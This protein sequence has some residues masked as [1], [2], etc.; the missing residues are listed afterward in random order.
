MKTLLTWE[1]IQIRWGVF[2]KGAESMEAAVG[3]MW[4]QYTVIMVHF[5]FMGWYT[6][7]FTDSN[8]EHN[9]VASWWYQQNLA[10]Y[11]C[12]SWEWS[13]GPQFLLDYMLTDFLHKKDKTS[14]F[15]VVVHWNSGI[16]RKKLFFAWA[17]FCIRDLIILFVNPD[18]HVTWSWEGLNAT[19]A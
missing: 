3:L 8:N 9:C 5:C 6:P 18:M 12:F 17:C 2:F 13:I 1:K 16:W 4:N 11:N 19:R 10:N 14:G 7:M 15:A